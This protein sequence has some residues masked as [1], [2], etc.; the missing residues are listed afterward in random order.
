MVRSVTAVNESLIQ[1]TAPKYNGREYTQSGPNHL[2]IQAF[3]KAWHCTGQCRS[4]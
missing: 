2:D 3:R 1:N 4:L